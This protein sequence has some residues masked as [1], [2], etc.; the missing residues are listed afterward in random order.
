MHMD[1]HIHITSH[2]YKSGVLYVLLLS[3]QVNPNIVWLDFVK[4]SFEGFVPAYKSQLFSFFKKISDSQ[5]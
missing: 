4:C 3:Q 1:V 5:V 2:V